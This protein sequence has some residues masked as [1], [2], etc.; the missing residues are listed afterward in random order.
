[1]SLACH[2]A[3]CDVVDEPVVVGVALY[4]LDFHH[5]ALKVLALYNH[6]RDDRL[7]QGS[8]HCGVHEGELVDAVAAIQLEYGVQEVRRDVHVFGVA[9]DLLED[10]VVVYVDELVPLA[11]FCDTGGG[12]SSALMCFV[13]IAE[14]FRVLFFGHYM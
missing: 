6:V 4:M 3:F 13:D 5:D 7:A 1:M 14:H 2:G 9:E 8:F 10:G 11:V 12:V